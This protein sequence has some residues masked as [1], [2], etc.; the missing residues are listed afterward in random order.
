M[1]YREQGEL[2]RLDIVRRAGQL[3]Q[4]VASSMDLLKNNGDV[5]VRRL[6]EQMNVRLD[7]AKAKADR[8][9][10]EPATNEVALRALSTIN[11]GLNNLNN[12]IANIV[13]RLE[14]ANKENQYQMSGSSSGLSGAS[15]SNMISQRQQGGLNSAGNNALQPLLDSNR[16]RMNLHQLSQ[17]FQAALN[18][19]QLHQQLAALRQRQQQQMA[20]LQLPGANR[21][22]AVGNNSGGLG[23][24]SG[25]P[26]MV[27]SNT[28]FSSTAPPTNVAASNKI[29]TDFNKSQ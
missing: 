16:I 10:N 18:G 2:L 23:L 20:L 27:A 3:Q 17:Q 4:V 14:A 24:G 21:Q 13:N 28:Q 8:I 19:S 7:Q 11:L 6:L 1:N 9:I 29:N 15:T 12:I 25:Q 22:A 5:I 26:P